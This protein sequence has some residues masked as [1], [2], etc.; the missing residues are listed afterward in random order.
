MTRFKQDGQKLIP[1][2][3]TIVP[4]VLTDQ[5]TFAPPP[6]TGRLV[7]APQGYLF[8]LFIFHTENWIKNAG[9]LMTASSMKTVPH[10]WHYWYLVLLCIATSYVVCTNLF[11]DFIPFLK[12]WT[13]WG[14]GF[15]LFSNL[16]HIDD[17]RGDILQ[18]CRDEA[19]EIIDTIRFAFNILVWWRITG[20]HLLSFSQSFWYCTMFT[21]N[22]IHS[23]LLDNIIATLQGPPLATFRI[24]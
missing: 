2:W 7:L 10:V 1:V 21:F 11:F 14:L 5:L 3:L 17:I 18:T 20:C 24:T 13:D 12:F 15:C 22:V 9:F 6:D 23:M 16:I 19:Q 8:F 4:A